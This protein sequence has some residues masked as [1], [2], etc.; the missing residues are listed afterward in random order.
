MSPAFLEWVASALEDLQDTYDAELTAYRPHPAP[1]GGLLPWGESSSGDRYYWH[2]KKR[3]PVGVVTGSRSD[4]FWEFPGTLSEFL[5]GW[6][7]GII[8]PLGQPTVE[9]FGGAR[10][11]VL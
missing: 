4:V 7:G 1:E 11:L 2:V 5:A 8:A 3:Q 6:L 10:F 9:Q